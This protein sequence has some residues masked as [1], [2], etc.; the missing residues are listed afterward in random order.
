MSKSE[1]KQLS[2]IFLKYDKD[3]RD[4]LNSVAY[5]EKAS[6]C[7]KVAKQTGDSMWEALGDFLADTG[8]KPKHVRDMIPRIYELWLSNVDIAVI[9]D[10][11]K[12]TK[13][14][15]VGGRC[16]PKKRA[17][18]EESESDSDSGSDSDSCSD[19]D[20]SSSDSDSGSDSE[21][22]SRDRKRKRSTKK[23]S[24]KKSRKIVPSNAGGGL[25][26]FGGNK[27]GFGQIF[28]QMPKNVEIKQVVNSK[29]RTVQSMTVKD[30]KNTR[31]NLEKYTYVKY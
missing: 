27:G 24:S 9:E 4:V 2:D 12:E 22:E 16:Y 5:F 11:N 25:S 8:I 1:I 15:C 7:Y 31:K 29:G 17:R 28:S 19:S 21:S 23:K 13:L 14:Q 6:D 26:L 18:A 20:Y 10:D 30:P 3:P